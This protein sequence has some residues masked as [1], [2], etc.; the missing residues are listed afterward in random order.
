MSL[1]ARLPKQ[2]DGAAPVVP[3]HP[4]VSRPRVA[5]LDQS[6]VRPVL[7]EVRRRLSET[8]GTS[9]LSDAALRVRVEAELASVLSDP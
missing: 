4:H 2:V 6:V 9:G 1:A 8:T 3:L 7:D 5:E